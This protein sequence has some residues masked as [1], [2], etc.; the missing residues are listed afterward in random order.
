MEE[1][2]L[3]HNEFLKALK[4]RCPDVYKKAATEQLVICVP[5]TGTLHGLAL[6]R[7]TFEAHV[8]KASPFFAGIFETLC[9]KTLDFEDSVLETKKGFPDKRRVKVLF[10][11]LHYNSDFKPFRVL[12]IEKPLQGGSQVALDAATRRAGG[13]LEEGKTLQ[14]CQALLQSLKLHD[15]TPL[16]K[17]RVAIADLFRSYV[18][19][20]GYL[21]HANSKLLA[22]FDSASNNLLEANRQT[23]GRLIPGEKSK[24]AWRR[25]VET[26][27]MEDAHPKLISSLAGLYREEDQ[28]VASAMQRKSNATPADLGADSRIACGLDKAV[29]LL[30]PL[31]S[32]ATPLDK[33]QLL[34]D[35][36][37]TISALVEDGK[38]K[39]TVPANLTLSADDLLP[40]HIFVIVQAKPT[41]L[42]TNA[43]LLSY[44]GGVG[45][46]GSES[47]FHVANLM[48]SADYLLSQGH[49]PT[50]PR[51]TLANPS[52]TAAAAS[53]ALESDLRSLVFSLGPRAS[54]SPQLRR[55]RRRRSRLR[56][57][58]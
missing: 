6:N 56:R 29:E 47:G 16:S 49:T 12:C 55:R 11:E 54:K 13:G 17:A 36:A 21:D 58:L 4:T 7:S 1:E 32:L 51:H 23:L 37:N 22:I 34:Q 25:C 2:D 18:I 42:Y 9:G 24:T 39:G 8:I 20:K 35:V 40:L 44:F 19:A 30:A 57:R 43:V 31:D 26:I 48:A 53:A 50:P 52:P 3:E 15:L 46:T 27:L 5:S 33:I 38:K 14:A 28:R 41:R 45:L 10:E